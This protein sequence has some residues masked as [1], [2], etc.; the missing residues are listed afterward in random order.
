MKKIFIGLL[1]ILFCFS[2]YSQASNPWN[3]LVG[4][5]RIPFVDGKP[6]PD[7][8]NTTGVAVSEGV[9]EFFT[10]LDGSPIQSLGFSLFI[11]EAEEGGFR[12]V[13][14]AAFSN[15]GSYTTSNNTS[16]YSFDGEV[17][18]EGEKVHLINNISI[19]N[20]GIQL[21]IKG[22]SSING[23]PNPDDDFIFKKVE[24]TDEFKQ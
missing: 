9:D 8:E 17:L 18:I 10:Y 6:V 23:I 22:T 12:Y 24:C 1:L 15:I 11:F 7:F 5:Y 4:C 21:I 16:A 3:N 14:N 20:D 13:Y 19:L 2:A